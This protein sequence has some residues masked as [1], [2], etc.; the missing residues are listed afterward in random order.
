MKNNNSIVS[1]MG[2]TVST[3]QQPITR[4]FLILCVSVA[5]L[6]GFVAGTRSTELFSVIGPLIGL[7][8]NTD[9]LDLSS[10]QTTYQQLKAN[11]DGEL[12]ARALVD[13][14]SRG[15]V[16]AA[17]DD[18]TVFLDAKEAKELEKDLTGSIGG[19]IGA[20]IGVR[21]DQPTILRI[22]SDQPADKAGLLA[23]DVIT[24]VNGEKTDNWTSSK[25]AEKL[26]GVEGTTVKVGILRG[27]EPKEFTITRAIIDN[28]SVDAKIENDI[29]IMSISRFDEKTS[30]LAR[31]AAEDFV[32]NDVK[33]VIVDLRG[34]GGGYL[35]AAQEMA[36]IWLDNKLVVSERSNGIVTE[37]LRSAS[38]PVLQ[39][40]K[41]VVLIDVDSASASEILAAALHDHG[42]A[43]LVGEK[44]YGKGSV[45]KIVPLGNGT[46]LKVTVARWYTPKG[47]SVSKVGITPDKKVGIT[48]ED[49]NAG[50]DPQLDAAK[51]IFN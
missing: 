36:S 19:G 4:S 10:M 5:V 48:K 16:E 46:Q 32:D 41:T 38:D 50:R 27:V 28:P 20:V 33:G 51:G 47:K 17:G 18:Y 9:T 3:K 25:T 26:R 35:E 44:T 13:G 23:G 31:Q 42:A 45:Q 12:D 24:A 37:E 2:E 22:L 7:K 40:I 30:T 15:L 43:T 6:V 1:K 34:N 21:S 29:G 11:F 49:I 8:P 14:A 39:G